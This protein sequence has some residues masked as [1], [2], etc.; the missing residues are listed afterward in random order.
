MKLKLTA[1]VL[2]GATILTVQALAQLP[3]GVTNPNSAGSMLKGATGGCQGLI[4]QATSLVGTFQGGI[5]NN[6]LG[7]IGQAK[8]S[9]SAGDQTACMTHANKALTMLK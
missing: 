8:S 5:K 4:D 1:A 2:A 9:L 7:E 3:A 6:I